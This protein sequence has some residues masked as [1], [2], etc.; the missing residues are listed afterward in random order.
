MYKRGAVWA[1]CADVFNYIC[2]CYWCSLSNIHKNNFQTNN[3]KCNT[4]EGKSPKKSLTPMDEF[5][6]NVAT[7]FPFIYAV[8]PG[9][10][11]T[12]YYM[13]ILGGN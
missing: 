13:I 5:K 8:L 1:I 3:S 11:V 7:K 12:Y 2:W 6:K 4:H 10:A 9:V